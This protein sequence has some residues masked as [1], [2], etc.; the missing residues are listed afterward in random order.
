[1][2]PQSRF[3]GWTLLTEAV[4]SLQELGLGVELLNPVNGF[5]FLANLIWVEVGG[6][7][8]EG[9]RS[10]LWSQIFSKRNVMYCK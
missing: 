2:N 7:R 9:E 5:F 1:M 3:M 10:H 6:K 8:N 4:C